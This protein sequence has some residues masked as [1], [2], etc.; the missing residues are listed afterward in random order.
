MEFN[1]SNKS[2]YQ[3][4]S[5]DQV[6]KGAQAVEYSQL[7]AIGMVPGCYLVCKERKASAKT[8]DAAKD[9]WL[10]GIIYLFI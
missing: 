1:S 7:P 3:P 5:L 10:P 9:H 6:S 8:G 4:Y 2:E